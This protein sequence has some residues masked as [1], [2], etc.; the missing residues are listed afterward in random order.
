MRAGWRIGWLAAALRD[1]RGSGLLIGI[2]QHIESLE[3]YEL[4]VL[5]TVSSYQVKII[6]PRNNPRG[7]VIHRSPIP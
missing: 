2:W 5:K 6:A 3:E 7:L 4:I 1:G